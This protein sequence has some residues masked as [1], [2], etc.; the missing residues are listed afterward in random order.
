MPAHRGDIVDRSGTQLA[1]GKEQQT[2]WAT[3]HQLTDPR[4]AARQLAKVLHVSRTKLEKAFLQH[5]SWYACVA[6]QVDPALAKKALDLKIVGVGTDTA[7]MPAVGA[8]AI[9]RKLGARKCTRQ[10]LAP[11]SETT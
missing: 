10:G 6:R 9:A 11:L 7:L 3:P 4:G 5:D 1:V 8:A 2:V